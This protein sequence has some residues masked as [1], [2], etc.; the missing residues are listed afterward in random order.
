MARRFGRNQRRAL[1]NEIVNLSKETVRLTSVAGQH[2]STAQRYAAELSRVQGDLIEWADRIV[3]LL[4]DTSAFA[5]EMATEGVDAGLFQLVVEEG[6]PYRCV[7]SDGL[8]HPMQP[9]Q[10]S[11][12]F[13]ARQI[14]D[15]FV[16]CAGCN[17]DTLRYKRQFFIQAPDGRFELVMDERTLQL[18]RQSGDAGLRRHLLDNMLAPWEKRK[19]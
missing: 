3:T 9:Q 8:M 18:L 7:P 12:V 19:S 4:G 6:R 1:R 15:L 11:V 14:M 16:V 5:R 10:I 13:K 17:S 2:H